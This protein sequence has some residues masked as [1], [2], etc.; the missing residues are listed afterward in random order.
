M[1]TF[2]YIKYTIN[3]VIKKLTGV[4]QLDEDSTWKIG[5]REEELVVVEVTVADEEPVVVPVVASPD[6]ILIFTMK[7]FTSRSRSIWYQSGS[8]QEINSV[9]VILI[10]CWP[11][12]LRHKGFHNCQI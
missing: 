6:A 7:Y 2:I 3:K 10:R 12:V 9:D 5:V 8:I 4:I 1:Y 11:S